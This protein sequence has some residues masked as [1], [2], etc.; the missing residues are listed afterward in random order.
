MST[1]AIS[2]FQASNI[3]QKFLKLADDANDEG[4][5]FH[6]NLWVTFVIIP[7]D[8]QTMLTTLQ[9]KVKTNKEVCVHVVKSHVHK[10]MDVS[11]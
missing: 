9:E 1:N 6:D 8:I 11:K 2:S 4:D 3:T 10:D 7:V 5:L